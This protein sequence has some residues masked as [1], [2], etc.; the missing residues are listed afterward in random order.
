M[1]TSALLQ[2]ALAMV[3]TFMGNMAA[4]QDE[5]DVDGSN[6]PLWEAGLAG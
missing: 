1:K 4:T 2:F 3:L 6:R 5:P